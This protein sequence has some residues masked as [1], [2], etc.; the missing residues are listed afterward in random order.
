[1]LIFIVFLVSGLHKQGVA[2]TRG[3]AV[4]CKNVTDKQILIRAAIY[5]FVRCT[6]KLLVRRNVVLMSS[7]HLKALNC[8][9]RVV[10]RRHAG[11]ALCVS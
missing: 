8:Q 11:D 10:R 5:V 3:I 2:Y 1:M 4:N 6:R 9:S 7:G